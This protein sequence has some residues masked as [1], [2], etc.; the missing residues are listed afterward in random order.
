MMKLLL[1]TAFLGLMFAAP[2]SAQDAMK[3]DDASMAKMQTDMGAMADPAMKANKD[4]AMKHMEEAKTAMKANDMA[5][6]TTHMGMAQMGMTMKCDDASMMKM[7]S[8][9]DAMTDPAMKDNAMKSMEMAK[10]AMKDNKVDEC[11]SQMGAAMEAM[12]EKM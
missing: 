10:T 2:A 9:M 4:M 5:G 6:C 7:Q 12:Y 11:M 8:D 1:S 3:C